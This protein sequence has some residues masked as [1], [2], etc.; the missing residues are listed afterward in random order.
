MPSGPQG[1]QHTQQQTDQQHR[2]A[3]ARLRLYDHQG[4]R[5][6]WASMTSRRLSASGRSGV[7]H[8]RCGWRNSPRE[9][10]GRRSPCHRSTTESVRGTSSE[11]WARN[12]PADRNGRTSRPRRPVRPRSAC[13]R[14]RTPAPA[15][16]W[17]SSTRARSGHR[18][19]F[20]GPLAAAPR[21][22]RRRSRR[23]RRRRSA[24]PAHYRQP[25]GRQRARHH[26]AGHRLGIL[27]V[28]QEGPGPP[29]NAPAVPRWRDGRA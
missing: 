13:R 27:A 1:G 24:R 21:S 29:P 6:R 28:A 12:P 22:R 17:S 23:A 14:S 2:F 8:G 10:I 25:S 19:G 11:A 15:P 16:G 3:G 9:S 7:P 4:H 20:R 26:R 5:W 18:P